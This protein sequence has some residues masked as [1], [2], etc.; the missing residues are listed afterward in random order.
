MK[1]FKI[2]VKI[3]ETANELYGLCKVWNCKPNEIKKEMLQRG[4]DNEIKE[5]T[6]FNYDFENDVLYIGF[7]NFPIYKTEECKNEVSLH[8]CEDGKI[9][10]FTI[11][12]FLK[13]VIEE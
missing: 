4:F 3:P 9:R 11:I 13:R 6:R 7:A 12:D 8:Y 5:S 2:P 10:G 1:L